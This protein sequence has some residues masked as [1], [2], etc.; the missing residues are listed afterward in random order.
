M[1]GNANAAALQCPYCRDRI[2]QADLQT[3]CANCGTQFHA[4]CWR[5]NGRCPVFGCYG[6][7][8]PPRHRKLLWY[9]PAVVLSLSATSPEIAAILSFLAL[10]AYVACAVETVFFASEAIAS[11]QR[12]TSCFLA[13]FANIVSILMFLRIVL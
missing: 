2:H 12:R 7:P 8:A 5:E 4:A 3:L 1:T 13:L 11:A 9:L 10:P 6:K